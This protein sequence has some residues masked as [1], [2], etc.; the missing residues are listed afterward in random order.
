MHGSSSAGFRRRALRPVD[1]GPLVGT[2]WRTQSVEFAGRKARPRIF[3]THRIRE[4][5]NSGNTGRERSD[6]LLTEIS[7]KCLT[8]AN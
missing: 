7:G 1:V 2:R 5:M 4:T 8:Y 3:M 6:K